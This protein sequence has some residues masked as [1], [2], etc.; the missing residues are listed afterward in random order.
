MLNFGRCKKWNHAT[1]TPQA[2]LVVAYMLY[3]LLIL[4]SRV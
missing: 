3:M 1:G 2:S 4:F